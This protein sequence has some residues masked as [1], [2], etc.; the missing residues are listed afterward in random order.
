MTEVD[1]LP[2]STK[3]LAGR[4]NIG[5]GGIR[6]FGLLW[7]VAAIGFVLAG[8]GLLFSA[9]WWWT[10]TIGTAVFSFLLC[11]LGLPVAKFGALISF[12]CDLN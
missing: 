11:I 8:I 5:D 9:S 7:V 3:L 2:Y 6:I 10:L 1:G 12:H 4:V